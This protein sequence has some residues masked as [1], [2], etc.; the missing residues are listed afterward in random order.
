[1][2]VMEFEKTYLRTYVR[3]LA[4]ALDQLNCFPIRVKVKKHR[5]S[6]THTHACGYTIAQMLQNMLLAKPRAWVSQR[7]GDFSLTGR[8][9][10]WG[11]LERLL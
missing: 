8:G 6:I 9:M 4:H 5:H 10:G 7:E 1:M 2:H 3:T 11:N